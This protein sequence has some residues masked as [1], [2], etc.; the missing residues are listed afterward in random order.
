MLIGVIGP[1]S[2]GLGF[3][4]SILHSSYNYQIITISPNDLKGN[5][6]NQL[7]SISLESKESE[8]HLHFSSK[9]EALNFVTIN[10]QSNFVLIHNIHDLESEISAFSTRPFYCSLAITSTLQLSIKVLSQN[11]KS[12]L[13]DLIGSSPLDPSS[14]KIIEQL[15]KENNSFDSYKYANYILSLNEFDYL[16][17]ISI[18]LKLKDSIDKLKM[19]VRPDWDFYFMEIAK[20]TAQRTNCMKR[21]VGAVLVSREFH[22]LISTGYNGT[23]SGLR[24]CFE[25]G[26]KR[27]NANQGSGTALSTCLCLHAEENAIFEAGRDRISLYGKPNSLD[28]DPQGV[29][30]YTTSCPCLYCAK[31]IIQ[32]GISEVVYLNSYYTD[33][34]VKQFLKEANVLVRS[35]K[36]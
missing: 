34:T 18:S 24:N 36:K 25:G 26:C 19:Y 6:E 28:R 9:E 27:C 17:E 15:E 8:G 22:R 16:N 14:T 11:Q 2:S 30:L 31:K 35:L 32:A 1:Y 20:L 3:V 5:I 4:V 33:D 21:R 29:V 13:L 7:N 23:P 12:S 10:Y